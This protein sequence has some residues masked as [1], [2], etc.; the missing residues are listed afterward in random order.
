MRYKIKEIQMLRYG[1]WLWAAKQHFVY[2]TGCAR[3]E[4]ERHRHI[5]IWMW[6]HLKY[7]CFGVVCWPA[8]FTLYD[9]STLNF[10]HARSECAHTHTHLG[11]KSV[12]K[13]SFAKFFGSAQPAPLR[14][15][16]KSVINTAFNWWNY[17]FVQ[18]KPNNFGINKKKAEAKRP[19]HT[20]NYGN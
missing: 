6:M 16:A 12:C 3:T 8:E 18:A 15:L 13:S 14:A 9:F 17:G 19:A 1:I 4:A 5:A 11:K 20:L 10:A 2:Y 7:F